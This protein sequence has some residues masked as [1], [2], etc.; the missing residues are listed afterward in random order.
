MILTE[1]DKAA[2]FPNVT[3]TGSAL[4]S[5]IAALQSIIYAKI[6]RD[7]EVKS[8]TDTIKTSGS[9]RLQYTPVAVITSVE[10]REVR[11][12]PYSF[13]QF[14]AA[15]SGWTVLPNTEYTFDDTDQKID[16]NYQSYLYANQSAEYRVRYTAGFDFTANTQ[17]VMMIKAI[18][19]QMLS[20][21]SMPSAQ[22]GISSLSVDGQSVSY[23]ST[24]LDDQM[25]NQLAALDAYRPRIFPF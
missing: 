9:I 10:R 2:Y 19:G 4:I 13:S 22:K 11:R 8:Y 6:G 17:E 12:N 1:P 25:S 24:K 23:R 7:L 20:F 5:A 16:I 18:A 21:Q 15:S 14:S 3:A